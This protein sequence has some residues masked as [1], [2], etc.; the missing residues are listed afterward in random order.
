MA[1]VVSRSRTVSPP[2]GDLVM[3]G[4]S[5]RASPSLDILR[6]KFDSKL[7]F[8]NHVLGIVS[9]VSQR[10]GILRMVKRIFVDTS[11]LLRCYFAFVISILVCCSLVWESAAECHLQLHECLVYSVAMLGFVPIR[12]SCRCVIDVVW[13]CLVCWTRLIK[14]LI[15]VCSTSFHL[16]LLEFDIPELRPQL[17]YWSLR[18]Q[19]V[20]RPNLLRLSCRLRFECGMT[21][22]TLCLTPERWMGSRVQLTVGRF[23]EL[24][25]LFLWPSCFWGCE[26]ILWTT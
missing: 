19:G 14:T 16:L 13:L 8:D 24:C 25:F 26:S 2:H 11:V 21:F 15:T 6:L 12:V 5:I 10:I 22:P 20:E 17:I 1:L 3:S 4:V 9:R 23:P 7:T 18:Y